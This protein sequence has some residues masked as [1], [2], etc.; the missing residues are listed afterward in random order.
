V[1]YNHKKL[2]QES[3]GSSSKNQ[4]WAAFRE[5]VGRSADI[6]PSAVTREMR[7]PEDLGID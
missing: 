6:E 4:A 1:A 2:A 5:L 3:G 7:F